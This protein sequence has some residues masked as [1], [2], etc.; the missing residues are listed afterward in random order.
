MTYFSSPGI[1]S[2]WE[3]I[4]VDFYGITKEQLFSKSRKREYCEPRQV[5]M[6]LDQVVL[7]KAQRDAGLRFKKNHATAHHSKRAIENL[8]KT[9]IEFR[10]RFTRLLNRLA[11]SPDMINKILK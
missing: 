11:I 7:K 6:Y 3:S 1:N 8:L 2:D 4:L 10:E 9:N 5:I